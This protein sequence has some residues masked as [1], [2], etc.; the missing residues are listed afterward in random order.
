VFYKWTEKDKG[1]W[2]GWK[3]GN[4]VTTS[5]VAANNFRLLNKAQ[6]ECNRR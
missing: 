3:L 1:F 6:R 4:G 5:L 2:Y